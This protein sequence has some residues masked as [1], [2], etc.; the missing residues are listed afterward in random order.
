MVVDKSE[1]GVPV[2][3]EDIAEWAERAEQI[4]WSG[5]EDSGCV[6]GK[7]KPVSEEKTTVSFVLPTSAY[8]EL[9]ELAEQRKCSKSEV[10]RAFVF[11]GL[12]RTS[13]P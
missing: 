13:A 4:D 12:L 3:D 10:L 1:N 7:L 8:E 2:T 9:R 11:D 5:Y 6:Y